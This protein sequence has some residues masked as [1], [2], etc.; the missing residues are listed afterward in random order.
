MKKIRS[1]CARI[2]AT[3]RSAAQW[4]ICRISRPPR[5]SKLMFSVEAYA[6]LIR[7]AV[8]VV[9]G[10]VVDDLGH[11]RLEP[12]RQERAG[13]QQDDERV[14]GDLAEQERP[15]VR[16]DLP[17]QHAEAPGAVE[18]VVQPA[19]PVPSRSLFGVMPDSSPLPETR[20]DRLVEVALR[21]QVSPRV[22]GD[23]QL[24]QRPR[25]RAEEHRGAARRVERRLVARAEDVV[26]GLL[27]ERRRA[28]DVG[29]DLGVG[30]RCRRPSSSSYRRR[31][32]HRR[33]G[34]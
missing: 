11:A 33:A 1:M 19:L 2:A 13:Q 17:E 8:E 34:T 18:P 3:N 31:L 30:R 16:E 6:S 22:R 21:D 25:G 29:A 28:A 14:E 27:V 24:R 20:A 23:R 4:W 7:D 26:G 5:T 10:A 9:V 32:Q 15:V 12:E